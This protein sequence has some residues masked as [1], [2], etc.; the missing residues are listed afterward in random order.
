[1]ES[2]SFQSRCS[3]KRDGIKESSSFGL[4]GVGFASIG[5]GSVLERLV[6]HVGDVEWAGWTFDSGDKGL[7]LHG[8]HWED[9]DLR[10]G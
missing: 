2:E 9:V 1:V 4:A 7:F 6:I 8:G 3:G 5:F 10:R